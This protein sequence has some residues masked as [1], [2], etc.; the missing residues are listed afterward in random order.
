MLRPRG[1]GGA[2][3]ITCVPEP[4]CVGGY[5]RRFRD[6]EINYMAY[7]YLHLSCQFRQ[8]QPDP[9]PGPGLRHPL[10]VHRCRGAADLAPWPSLA[11]DSV[12][13]AASILRPTAAGP[14]ANLCADMTAARPRRRGWYAQMTTCAPSG[15]LRTVCCVYTL[16]PLRRVHSIQ[17]GGVCRRPHPRRLASFLAG[18]AV[19]AT[20]SEKNLAFSLLGGLRK[21][22]SAHR[23]SS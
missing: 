19:P 22:L 7:L 15:D 10:T 1:R 5:W 21:P 13:P 6:F 18:G 12:Q 14:L 3:T 2:T 9:R 16:N 23:R 8:S 20:L 4:L 11:C 17:G